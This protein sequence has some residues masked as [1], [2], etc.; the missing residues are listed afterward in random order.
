MHKNETVKKIMCTKLVTGTVNDK[1]SDVVSK[2]EAGGFHHLP[3]VS[4]D[5]LI[6]VVSHDDVLRVSF[7]NVF[8]ASDKSVAESLDHTIHI[9]NIMQRNL[10]TMRDNETIRHACEILAKS[11]FHALPVVDESNCLTGMVTTKDLIKHLMAQYS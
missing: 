1:F 6:G 7:S 4:G 10:V 11:E 2:M 3:I 8:I 9:E 5:K